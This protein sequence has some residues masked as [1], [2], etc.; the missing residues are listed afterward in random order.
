MSKQC[1][2][3]DCIWL[4]NLQSRILLSRAFNSRCTVFLKASL[5]IHVCVRVCIHVCACVCVC[6]CLC[7]CMCVCVCA[8]VCVCVHMRVR[9]CICVC[10]CACVRVSVCVCM[11]ACICVSFAGEGSPEIREE[12]QS[13]ESLST[14]S[15]CCIGL[16]NWSPFPNCLHF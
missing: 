3:K 12:D 13:R 16:V 9:V 11:C 7:V 6:V 4:T 14:I 15:E 8:C 5:Q 2:A 1:A 10:V